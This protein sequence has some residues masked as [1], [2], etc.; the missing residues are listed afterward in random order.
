MSGSSRLAIEARQSDA[1][2]FGVLGVYC[3]PMALGT[4]L[5]SALCCGCVLLATGACS[6][7]TDPERPSNVTAEVSESIHTVVQVRWRTD[8]ASIGYVEYG[9]T[10]ELG[11]NTPLEDSETLEHSY[12]LL[13]LTAETKYYYRV[14]TWDGRDAGASDVATITTGSLPIGMPRL[15]RKGDGNDLFTIVPILGSTTAVTILDPSG[16]IVWYHTDDRELDFYRARLSVNGK[17]LI[18]NAASVSGDPADNSELVRVALDGSGG[19]SI[20]V[21][22]LAHDFVE[23]P[24][25]TLAAMVVEYRDFEGTPLRGDKIVE[26]D[27]DGKQTTIWTSWDCFDPSVVTGDDIEHGWTF[28]NALD[29][30]PVDQKYYL[31]MRNFSSIAKIDRASHACEWVLG[32]TAPTLHFAPGSARFLHQH[33]FQLRGNHILIFDNDGSPGTES[34]VLE[35]ELDFEANLATQVW[36]YV[37]DP[38]VYTFVLGEPTRLAN[39]DTFIDWATAGQLERVN[40]AGESLW[41]VNSG[42]GAAFGFNTLAMTLYSA[43]AKNP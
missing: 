37:S 27:A 31:G 43:T 1:L 18:Y 39:G 21:P 16:Q 2:Q 5:L 25:G 26:I 4:R 40:A 19:S 7:S 3:V 11:F 15:T 12:S 35:Y 20:K 17:D 10:P 28:A 33:Q 13:G 24:D 29:Y 30:D 34:R 8:R 14:V 9:P 6:D 36:S 22:L 23:H 41:K 42:A 38:T 32:F